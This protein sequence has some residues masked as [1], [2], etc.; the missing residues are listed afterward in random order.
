MSNKRI[1]I[2]SLL[3][4]FLERSGTQALQLVVSIVLARI[5]S[6]NDFGLI[7]LVMVF[8]S[9]AGVFVQSG[10]NTALI[11]KKDADSLDFSSIFYLSIG[12]A[13]GM[14]ILLFLSAPWIADFY[15]HPALV[16]V[17]RVLGCTLLLQAFNSIQE[18][19]LARKMMFKKLF[20]RSI[21]ALI[22]SGILGILL[23]SLGFGIW[24]LVVQQIS[25]AFLICVIMWFTVKWRPHLIFSW[26]RIHGLF[27]FGWKLLLS[28]LLDIGHR[29][30]QDLVIGKMFAP[31]T[32]GFYNRGKQFPNLIVNNI[33]A[34]IQSVMLPVLA[35]MQEDRAEVKRMMRRAIVSSS[36]F[37][38]PLMAGL[39]AAADPLVRIVLGEKWMPCVPFLQIYCFIYAFWPIH[40]SN[41]SAIN[42]IGR[43]DLFLKLEILKRCIGF[44]FLVLAII[45]FRTPIAIALGC[46]ISAVIACFIN[47]YPNKKLLHYG[48]LEQM[49]DILPYFLSSVF[50]GGVLFGLSRIPMNA[51]I[52][53]CF[54]IAVGCALY[55][56]MAKL[57]HFEGLD[58]M[59]H[60]FKEFRQHGK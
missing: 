34:S 40:T 49:K 29:N 17:I 59:L 54:Q 32:L 22:P 46:A 52:L 60:T 6:P 1:I 2:A 14:Y 56:G 13:L 42:A 25:N 16:P 53:L 19:Y 26:E 41:L 31:A 47:A 24:A 58:Y 5:L 48:Y 50:M 38:L 18:A 10:F 57:L 20:Y 11:Q 27:S 51:G 3:W 15:S 39:A 55:T 23:A 7:A 33:N 37:L 9:I 21:G 44:S 35:S 8:I 30:I 12:V 28:S 45:L 36:F 4:K 43:S